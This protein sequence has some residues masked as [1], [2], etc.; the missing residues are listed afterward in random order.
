M[1]HGRSPG[2]AA[3]AHAYTSATDTPLAAAAART[4]DSGVRAIASSRAPGSA[5]VAVPNR[6]WNGAQP[7]PATRPGTPRR[8]QKP[9]QA[10]GSRVSI[11]TRAPSDVTSVA[12]PVACPV[13]RSAARSVARSGEGPVSGGPPGS[14]PVSPSRAVSAARYCVRASRAPCAS[15][16]RTRSG[17]CPRRRANSA[18]VLPAAARTPVTAET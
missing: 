12:C 14:S 11:S 9:A 7:C 10:V 17:S 6:C 15:D 2:G 5:Q 8:R 3:I 16:V 1:D 13:A 4:A 18:A